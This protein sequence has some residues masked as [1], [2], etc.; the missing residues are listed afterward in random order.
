M[1]ALIII[2]AGVVVFALGMLLMNPSRKE[3]KALG[4]NIIAF[5]LAGTTEKTQRILTVWKEPGRRAARQNIHAD[6]VFIPGY[7][8]ILFGLAWAPANWLGSHTWHWAGGVS[9]VVAVLGIVAGAFDVVEDVYLLRVLRSTD[10]SG[11]QPAATWA[12]RAAIAKFALILVVLIWFL[13]F[14]A[15]ARLVG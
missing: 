14:A 3:L 2:I 4:T 11:I 12:R 13:M 9:R 10:T 8:A 1:M 15:P 7:A 6:F 5:E